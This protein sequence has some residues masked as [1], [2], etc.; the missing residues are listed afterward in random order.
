MS[1][2][3]I[4]VKTERDTALSLFPGSY[5][6]AVL[7]VFVRPLG[8]RRWLK[9]LLVPDEGEGW[10]ELEAKANAAARAYIDQ[11]VSR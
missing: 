11:A 5:S 9:F 3:G 1:Q 7:R 8:T 6:G 2:G 10:A 4:E